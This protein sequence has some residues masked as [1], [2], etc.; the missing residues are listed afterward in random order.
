M[1]IP[2]RIKQ[3]RLALNLTQGKFAE[4]IA[5]STSHLAGMELGDKKINNRTI[6]FICMEFGVDEHWLKTGEGSM[7]DD[8]VD[9]KTLK[10]TSLFKMLTPRF[11]DFT[12]NHLNELVELQNSTKQP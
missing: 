8:G 2:E 3:V 10:A 12:L 7:F 1:E 11:Q 5:I 9:T 6:R 4:R